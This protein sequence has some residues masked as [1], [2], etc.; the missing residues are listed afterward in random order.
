MSKVPVPPT[1]IFPVAFVK[2]T[3][4]SNNGLDL[5]IITERDSHTLL[6]AGNGRQPFIRVDESPHPKT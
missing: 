6:I 5:H 1:R 2:I 3:S 4:T